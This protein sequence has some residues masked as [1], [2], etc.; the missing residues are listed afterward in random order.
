MAQLFSGYAQ[1]RGFKPVSTAG[2]RRAI[3]NST[4]LA[5]VRSMEQARQLDRNNAVN[6]HE[7]LQQRFSIDQEARQTFLDLEATAAGIERQA[8]L[9]RFDNEIERMKQESKDLSLIH[10]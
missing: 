7:M 5:S 9:D 2:R 1:Q 6:A 10:I 3:Q 8:K 4:D